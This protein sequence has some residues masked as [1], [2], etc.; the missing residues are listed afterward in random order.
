MSPAGHNC[1]EFFW[2]NEICC[3]ECSLDL[4][5]LLSL[6]LS[7]VA[8]PGGRAEPKAPA[9]VRRASQVKGVVKERKIIARYWLV[10]L[11]LL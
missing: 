2:L 7:A 9:P 5:Y 11:P 3:P 4:P 8:S 1:K 10:L 6:L